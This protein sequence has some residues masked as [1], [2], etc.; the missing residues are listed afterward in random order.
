M[1]KHNIFIK[2]NANV[3]Y[4]YKLVIVNITM[5]HKT[6]NIVYKENSIEDIS[7]WIVED[8]ARF[9]KTMSNLINHSKGFKCCFEFDS[10]EDALGEMGNTVEPPSVILLDISLNGMSGIEG[11]SKF[12]EI[13]PAINIIMLT[14]H[15]DDNSVFD[16]LCLGASGY[17]LKESSPEIVIDAIVEVLS[18]VAPMNMSIAKKVIDMFK[19]LNPPKGNYGLTTREKEILNFLVEGLNKKQIAE[20][21]FVSFH[22]VNTHVKNIYEKLQVNTRSGLVSKAFKEK[23]I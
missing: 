8:N 21:L 10:C 1:L 2:N 6:K 4:H 16:A 20:K 5:K 7:I 15:D 12:K 13:S 23:L 19:Q 14:I 17:L 18:G 3:R 11:I 22:T 9:R